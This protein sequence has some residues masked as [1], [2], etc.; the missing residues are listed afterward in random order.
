MNI[1]SLMVDT[2][3]QKV[4]TQYKEELRKLHNRPG[5]P[6]IKIVYIAGKVTGL[7]YTG[8]RAKFA[9]REVQLIDAGYVVINPCDLISEHEDW[10]TAMKISLALL[11][12]ADLISLLPDWHESQGATLEKQLADKFNIKTLAL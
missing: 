2:F 1:Q 7:D 9:R 8:V 3:F 10:Q 6:E 11:S 5:Y 4:V 12:F